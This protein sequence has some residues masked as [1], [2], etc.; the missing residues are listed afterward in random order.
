[1]P[2]SRKGKKSTTKKSKSSSK[3]HTGAFVS[4]TIIFVLAL[5]AF[6]HFKEIRLDTLELNQTAKNYIV[7]QVDF[8]FPDPA[9]T[10]VL[11]QE[12]L[13]DV[14]LVYKI[15]ES[16][17]REVR[18]EFEN[19]LIKSGDWREHSHL[20]FD[21]IYNASD[22]LE[23]VLSEANLT[24]VRTLKR[25]EMS[26]LSTHNFYV[27]P[28]LTSHKRITLPESFWQAVSIKI[29]QEYGFSPQAIDTV[30]NFFKTE[31]WDV[32]NDIHAQKLFQNSIEQ[33][34][35][36]KYTKIPAGGRII[37]KGERV[38]ER[39]I[40]MMT[41]MKKA[42]RSLNDF[43]HPRQIFAS[44]IFAIIATSVSAIYLMIRQKDLMKDVRKLALFITII[45]LLFIVTKVLEWV[46][47]HVELSW[48]NIFRYPIFVPFASI[49]VCVL[50][51]QEL[52]VFAT[53]FLTVV[54]GISLAVEHNHFLF[55]NFLTGII[56]VI[57]ATSI[58]WRKEVFVVCAKIWITGAFVIFGFNLADGT[59]FSP[60]ILIDFGAS[61]INLFVIAI[62]LIGIMPVLESTF[63]IMID[64]TLM[65]FMNPT[66]E[67]LRQLSIE[68][69]GTYQ[70][71]LSIGHIAE[72]VANAIGANGLFCRVTTLYH[73]I[74]KLN[75]PQYFTENIMLSGNKQFDIHQLLTAT[76]SAYIIKA[77]VTDGVNLAK[78]YKLPQPFIDI[79][80]Q[81][82][83]TTLIKFFYFKQLEEVGGNKD[84]VDEE[85]FRYP[86]PKPQTKEAGI[87]MLADSIE[88]ASRSLE[89]N[90]EEAI[91]K[92]VHKIAQD[93]IADGQ[94]DECPLT[95]KELHTIKEKLAEMI[96]ATHH[97]RI[98][99]PEQAQNVPDND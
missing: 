9:A 42:L 70:H 52:A 8:Q 54:L 6:L 73:D 18:R 74:G 21:E 1:M 55:M 91:A 50:L 97:L 34:I 62:L 80:E 95:F 37:E 89:E 20:T 7:A 29:E 86:G 92:L 15:N 47:Y 4:I 72:Y 67:L 64:M 85:V 88:A 22:V 90:S 75:T 76:E 53:F 3:D 45:L 12:A 61:L 56:A 48:M 83:G 31:T 66:N 13:K 94:F 69:P 10:Y 24:D 49:L 40:A 59:I 84:D 57:T 78:Q 43:W 28:Y 27:V 87:I 99:Y 35:P 65:E 23:H 32:Y 81:H 36:D 71:S 93:K 30:V 79:I 63:N 39:H 46:V 14:N 2:T 51:N 16:D 82:H 96:K 11:R 5:A 68:A 38:N 41:S 58:K 26:Q 19:Y 44:L 98:K 77:H 60:V 25:R 33:S 17:I